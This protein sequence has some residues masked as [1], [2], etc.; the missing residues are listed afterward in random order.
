LFS[1]DIDVSAYQTSVQASAVLRNRISKKTVVST[2]CATFL[3]LG[4][5]H[6]GGFFQYQVVGDPGI[7]GTAAPLNT[8]VSPVQNQPVPPSLR[9]PDVTAQYIVTNVITGS[10]I[11]VVDG[12]N[13]VHRVDILGV[14]AP[15]LDETFGPESKQVLSTA[16]LGKPI[17][18]RLRKFTKEADTIAEVLCDG[19][20]V[21]VEQ[22][23]TGLAILA[24]GE[25][26]GLAESEQRLYREAAM[27]AKISKYGI[28]GGNKPPTSE[29]ADEVLSSREP[30]GESVRTVPS[31]RMGV[32]ASISG[33][34]R[35]E[36]GAA[37]QIVND[38][39]PAVDRVLEPVYPVSETVKTPI[40][41]SETGNLPDTPK[42]ELTGRPPSPVSTSGRTFVRGPRGG[43]YYT[44][45]RG[46]KEYVDRAKCR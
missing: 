16:L 36:M 11:D 24:D 4:I 29:I 15:R 5:A 45:S 1:S 39:G 33:K 22:I 32:K 35:P 17:T 28:W 6:F 26:T 12:N 37:W 27:A 30:A 46:N 20:N 41:R 10:A 31:R 40:V 18:V 9:F 38:A 21:G 43:C 2:C 25:I 34:V 14:R 44:N 13:L 19:A 42:R 8:E 23:R 7:P 3:L